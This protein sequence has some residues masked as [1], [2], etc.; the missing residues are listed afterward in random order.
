M[1]SVYTGS[2]YGGM[3]EVYANT[4]CN[5]NK[6]VVID[7]FGSGYCGSSYS[8]S[9]SPNPSVGE[10]IISIEDNS[11]EEPTLKSASTETTFDKEAEWEYEVYNTMQNLKAKQTKIHGKSTQLNTQGWKEGVYTVRAKYKDLVLTGKLVLK[12]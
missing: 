5:E 7:Y 3:V 10:A 4:C 9:I 11:D 6:K 8:I 2:T 12:K 1:I